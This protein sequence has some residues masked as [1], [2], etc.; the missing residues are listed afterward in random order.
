MNRSTRTIRALAAAALVLMLVACAEPPKKPV[1]PPPD[2]T[3]RNGVVGL[4]S[5]VKTRGVDQSNWKGAL[6]GLF[7][8][9]SE[10]GVLS[11][12]YEV[13]VF[14]D[15]GT[16][17]TVM[18]PQRPALTPGQKVRVTGNKIELRK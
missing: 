3:P 7:S 14:Y 2:P 16:T 18:L 17:G 5:E 1:A 12:A 11:T 4:V 13:T 9:D 10:K 8:L 6:E 15:D